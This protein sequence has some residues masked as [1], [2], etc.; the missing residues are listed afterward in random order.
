MNHK[1]A[2]YLCVEYELLRLALRWGV[3]G[4]VWHAVAAPWSFGW[5]GV[6]NGK[7]GLLSAS[8]RA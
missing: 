7:N 2:K 3:R 5:V 6:Q 8:L 1:N 4:P